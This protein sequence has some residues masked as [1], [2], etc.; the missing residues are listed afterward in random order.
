MGKKFLASWYI[1]NHL[2][3]RNSMKM[4]MKDSKPKD[5]ICSGEV[6][7][8]TWYLAISKRGPGEE[9]TP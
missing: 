3:K 2:K 5:R 9:Q 7:R 1:E 8:E 6:G 4:S